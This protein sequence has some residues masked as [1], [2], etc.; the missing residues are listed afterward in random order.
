[1]A[2]CT[3]LRANIALPPRLEGIEIINSTGADVYPGECSQPRTIDLSRIVI[4][5]TRQS[6]LRS[7]LCEYRRFFDSGTPQR[8]PREIALLPEN[9]DIFRALMQPPTHPSKFIERIVVSTATGDKTTFVT[10]K[11]HHDQPINILYNPLLQ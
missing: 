6:V 7:E 3:R 2:R 1:M 10:F 4:D 8:P 5:L 11:L 9:K